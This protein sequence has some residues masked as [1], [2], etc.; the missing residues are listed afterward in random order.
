MPIPC[1]LNPFGITLKENLPLTFTAVEAS[2]VK[3]NATGSPTVAGLHYRLGT[4]GT[5][6]PYTIGQAIPLAAGGKVQFWN[7]AEM[8]STSNANY[9]QFA[10]TGKIEGAGDIQ[11][12]L[13]GIKSVPD[14]SLYYLFYRCGALIQAPD[15]TGE[16]L[17]SSCYSNCLRETGITAMPKIAAKTP[18]TAS[19]STMFFRCYSLTGEVDLPI[20]GAANNLYQSACQQ[21]A[22]TRVHVGL[23]S[24]GYY[25]LY[26]A[27]NLCASLS[28]I[29][30]DFSSWGDA[31]A[32]N[33]TTLWVSGVAAEGTF[34]KPA[35]LPEEYGSNRI[36]EGWTVINK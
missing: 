14:F 35:A 17:G 28:N 11:S 8:L 18:G 15:F 4:S 3:I 2:T 32:V 24:L 23:V 12:L 29:E 6:L 13:N 5:W 19:M 21:T 33:A 26:S 10:M 16:T 9:C 34:I 1:R 36:P 30:V 20:Q 27:F 22:I 25:C 31:S 7:S